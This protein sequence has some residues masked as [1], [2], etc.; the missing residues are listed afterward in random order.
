MYANEMGYLCSCRSHTVPR[1]K[2]D[3]SK[4]DVCT[5]GEVEL[6]KQKLDL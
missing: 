6:G 3:I 4:K 5:K 1:T 2:F